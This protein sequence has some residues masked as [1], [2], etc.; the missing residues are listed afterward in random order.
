[1]TTDNKCSLLIGH[2]MAAAVAQSRFQR[3][4]D[5][6]IFMFCGGGEYVESFKIIA[7]K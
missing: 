4:F 7:V 1:V 6:F 3:H 5:I 2:F